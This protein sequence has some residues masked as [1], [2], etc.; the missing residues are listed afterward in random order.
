[1]LLLKKNTLINK[2]INFFSGEYLTFNSFIDNIFRIKKKKVFRIYIPISIIKFLS[3][4]KL[5]ELFSKKNLYN[6]LNQKISYNYNNLI[7][8]KIY[9]DKIEDIK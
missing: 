8:K 2:T 6:V 5:F 4:L 7:K 9:L 1:L 3:N